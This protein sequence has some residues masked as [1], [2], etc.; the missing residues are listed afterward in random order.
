M[1]TPIV[2]NMKVAAREWARQF[3]TAVV[4]SF[5]KTVTE[6]ITNSDTSYKRKHKLPDA[7]GLVEKALAFKKGTKFDLAQSKKDFAE[8]APERRIE[9]HLYTAK[10]HGRP[11]RTCE[12]VDLAEGLDV[13]ELKAAFETLAADKSSVSKGRPGRSLFGRGVTDVVLGHN[14][15]VFFSYKD[16]I[17]NKLEFTFD[18]KKDSEPV[19]KITHL[20]KPSA[21]V[22]KDIHLVEGENGSCVRFTLH[23]D[24]HIPDEG[25]IVPSL[26]QFYMLRLINADPNVKVHLIQYR[27]GKRTVKDTLD[28]D[29]PIGDVVETFSFSISKPVLEAELPPLRVDGIVCRADV[30]GGLPGKEA[31]EQ[32]A[33][34]LLLVDDKDAVLD[35][36]LL[37]QFEGAPYLANIFGIVR[38]SNLRDVL[39][40]FLNEGKDSPLTTTRD[41]FEI[42]HE[43]SKL[44]F[45]EL[46]RYLEPIYKRE[47]ERFNKSLASDISQEA[48]QRLND[49]IKELNRF[50]KE[51]IGESEGTEPPDTPPIA[52]K[53]LQ[54]I[55]ASTKLT[56]GRP[57]I[58]RVYL[59][60]DV[61]NRNGNIVYESSNSK[62]ELA[63]LSHRISDGKED[64]D[65]LIY[66][67]SLKC[68]ALH[69]S[70][71]ITVLADGSKEILEANL[72]V[73]DVIA[74]SNV[75]A[76]E[77]MEFRP[78]ESKGQPHRT[79]NIVLYVN[80]STIPVGRKIKLTVEKSTGQ[81]GLL[82]EGK[83]IVD[84][85]SVTFQR[86]HII[87]GTNVGRIL[88]PWRGT[89][90]G[91]AARILAET[92]KPDGS[93]A[94]A[95]AKIVVEQPDDSGGFIKD[96]KYQE[97]RSEKCSDLVD[98]IIYINS[99]HYLNSVVFGAEHEYAGRIDRDRTAQYRL[100]TLVVEQSVFRLAEE[101]YTRNKLPIINRA[102]VTSIREYV[103]QKTHKIAPQI[104]RVLMPKV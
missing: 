54:F 29:F 74:E 28:C 103:D 102:P 18:R 50:L 81:I 87:S 32:R 92:K 40:W 90:W 85:I 46:A 2:F 4:K 34:G 12:I 94:H 38:I 24:C 49:A 22:L 60:K 15:G 27:A 62:I 95:V 41:G 66:Q 26:T 96:V 72:D 37:P 51:L 84:G 78:K 7:A 11:A 77:E 71:K 35:L 16:G 56:I 79:N 42:K 33:N 64:R 8:K 80:S 93:L 20:G 88:I 36:T 57:R 25:T 61:A 59:R 73:I 52:T 58:V 101:D 10:G 44:L 91:Q 47:E 63:P 70:G 19:G 99:H 104:I 5:A 31:R 3:Y 9:I 45:K 68:D 67:L 55:P 6:P 17:L 75:V 98:G 82:E 14:A 83:E 69:E 39:S 86:E 21:T 23:E 13:D 76:P 30:K 89:G 48:R 97:L 1:Q 53:S 100:A 65:Y 43:F